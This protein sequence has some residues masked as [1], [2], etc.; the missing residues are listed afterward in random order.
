MKR[1]FIVFS[2]FLIVSLIIGS[3]SS[4]LSN[5]YF[6]CALEKNQNLENID[7]TQNIVEE[8]ILNENIEESENFIENEIIEENENVKLNED[9][10]NLEIKPNEE[11][12]KENGNLEN[13]NLDSIENYDKSTLNEKESLNVENKTET[14]EENFE[15]KDV[16][17]EGAKI[18]VSG[19]AEVFVSPDSAIIK[20]AIITNGENAEEIEKENTEKTNAL[21]EKLVSM[22]IN[23]EDISTLNYTVY[24]KQEY[25]DGKSLDLG[26]EISNV[27]EIN[28]KNLKDISS[29]N[30]ILLQNGVSEIYSVNFCVSD[31]NSQY[32]IALKDA[33]ENAKRKAQSLIECEN[34]KICKIIEQSQITN[35]CTTYSLKALNTENLQSILKDKISIRASVVVE[36]CC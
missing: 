25:V 1:K 27:L 22:N 3:L 17:C 20:F 23:R 36:F 8:N 16:D 5:N 9:G 35:G 33:L 2:I 10:E 31:Q 30:S 7:I 11:I 18:K 13:Q 28:V 32:F 29:I 34:M 15:I 26:F 24:K 12:D 14:L 4:S 21:I 19:S 6:L